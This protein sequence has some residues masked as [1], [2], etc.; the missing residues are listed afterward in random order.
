MKNLKT[1]GISLAVSLVVFVGLALVIYH[2]VPLFPSQ[3]LNE[4]SEQM[5]GASITELTGTDTMS[6]FPTTYNANLNSLNNGKIEISTTT[7]P[8]ITDLT[9]L[10]TIGTIT[11]GVWNGTLIDGLYGGTGT[12]SPTLN[13]VMIGNGSSGL[14]VIGFG[15]SGQFLTSQ[16][17]DTVPQWTTSSIDEAGNFS[18][19]GTNSWS[20]TSTFT[21]EVSSSAT[22]T[23]TGLLI[24]NPV[25][26]IL[27]STTI[28]GLTLPQPVFVATTTGA[29]LLS[30]ANDDL[31]YYQFDGFA[32]SSGVNGETIYVQTDGIVSGFTGLFA[33]AEYFVQD[34]VGTIATT[35]GTTPFKIGKAISTTQL[36]LDREK[37]VDSL[38]SRSNATEHPAY[39][40]TYVY[41]YTSGGTDGRGACPAKIDGTVVLGTSGGAAQVIVGSTIFVGKG[42]NWQMDCGGGSGFS[43]VIKSQIFN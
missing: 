22:T 37:R 4:N 25:V 35:T 38:V 31:K 34:A 23:V 15:N 7:L 42:H 40:D 28:T 43:S 9:G 39:A 12:T 21:G 17:A 3:L 20:N 5:L 1:I 13:M 2:F 6:D 19:T 24:G 36:L 30:D 29:L 16:G 18:W 10:D 27:A 8:L 32:V 41:G 33:G 26:P 14:K 11:V